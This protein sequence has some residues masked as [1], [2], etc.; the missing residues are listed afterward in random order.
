VSKDAI[1]RILKWGRGYRYRTGSD[2][3][4]RVKTYNAGE[5]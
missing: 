2:G 1:Q 3:V 5:I 4:G